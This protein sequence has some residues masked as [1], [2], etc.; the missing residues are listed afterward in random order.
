MKYIL[1]CFLS[2]VFIDI[3]VEQ[4]QTGESIFTSDEYNYGYTPAQNYYGGES[5]ETVYEQELANAYYLQALRNAV[6]AGYRPVKHNH[7]R[8]RSNNR[9]NK[10]RR[11]NGRSHR[12]SKPVHKSRFFFL[13]FYFLDRE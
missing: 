2:F 3:S 7:T 12:K 11:K 9:N 10:M 4:Y 6:Y 8:R 1:F 13:L 5:L